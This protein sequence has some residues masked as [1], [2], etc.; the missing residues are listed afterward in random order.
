MS[1]EIRTPLN[2]VIGLTELLLDTPLNPDQ[3]EFAEIA[4]SSGESLRVVIND[5]AG[6]TRQRPPDRLAAH[7]GQYLYV[8]VTPTVRGRTV[9]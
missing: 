2:G 1:H 3:R 8:A 5:V 7:H 4:R 9:R 6:T